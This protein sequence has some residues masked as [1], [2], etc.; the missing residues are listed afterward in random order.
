[1]LYGS[2]FLETITH[3][4]ID[5]NKTK[6]M[7]INKTAAV[8]KTEMLIRRPVS[9]VFEA[10]ANPEIT[11]KFWF[12]KSSGRLEEGKKREWTWEMYNL[13]VPVFVKSIVPGKTILIEW[14]KDPNKTTVEWTFR[15]V[16]DHSTL[17]SIVHSG[18]TGS[19]EEI[20]SQ[21]V[22]STGGFSLVLA[23]LK[24]YLEHGVQLNLIADRY[25]E[26]KH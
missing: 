14:G 1:M 11:T 2:V 18:F 16:N 3:G 22:D 15:Q 6:I 25:S 4:I 8:A 26:G 9:E 12:T 7:V 20:N 17:V 5:N 13:T 23:G 19:E 21:V 24:A 10:F